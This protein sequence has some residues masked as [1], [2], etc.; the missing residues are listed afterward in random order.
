M[1]VQFVPELFAAD[2]VASQITAMKPGTHME[3]RLKSKEKLR[4]TRGD[5]SASGFTLLNKSA[6]D[7][8][9]TFA[10]VT[11]VTKKSTGKRKALIATAIVVGVG[12]VVV[13]TFVVLAKT[14]TIPIGVNLGHL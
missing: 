11:S 7:R 8:Q 14:K 5:V 4:G 3:V 6:A 9:I 10:E 12:V 2:T 13:V 1:A